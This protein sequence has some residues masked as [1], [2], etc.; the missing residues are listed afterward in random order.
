MLVAPELLLYHLRGIQWWHTAGALG[1]L[2]AHRIGAHLPCHEALLIDSGMAWHPVTRE[3]VQRH[4]THNL[5]AGRAGQD[6]LHN[7]A[8]GQGIA[9]KAVL[10]YANTK[11]VCA[12]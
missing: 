7:A 10:Y 3:D 4:I 2:Q 5:C 6:G 11:A 8:G 12:T 1:G 9:A